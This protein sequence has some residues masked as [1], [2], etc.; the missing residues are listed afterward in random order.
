ME[1]GEV[2]YLRVAHCLHCDHHY[3]PEDGECSN[4]HNSLKDAPV[5][6][7]ADEE[8]PQAKP[9]PPR[10]TGRDGKSYPAHRT[11]VV[12]SVGCGPRYTPRQSRLSP[13]AAPAWGLCP[14]PGQSGSPWPG[15]GTPARAS[16]TSGRQSGAE[17]GG[18][19]ERQ[20]TPVKARQ[21]RP[22]PCEGGE[23]NSS[24]SDLPRV[25]AWAFSPGFLPLS[26]CLLDD[27]TARV[28]M[29][30]SKWAESN[31]PP[32]AHLPLDLSLS[33]CYIIINRC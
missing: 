31:A 3:P 17:D 2:F 27:R 15:T 23:G 21:G 32:V 10:I 29:R 7:L 12:S 26:P 16:I 6:E 18:W 28:L 22:G 1:C 24:L 4:C 25:R 11:S 19:T 5:A 30:F 9:N 13:A 8:A 20:G 14:W 33:V